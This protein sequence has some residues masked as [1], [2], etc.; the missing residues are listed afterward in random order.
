VAHQTTSG[1]STATDR[2]NMRESNMRTI[3]TALCLLEEPAVHAGLG[4]FLGEEGAPNLSGFQEGER[5]PLVE[6]NALRAIATVHR[7]MIDGRAVRFG[8]IS[9]R[10]AIAA[11]YPDSNH[12]HALA[13]GPEGKENVQNQD[14][15]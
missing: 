14:A 8:A 15:R 13:A 9:D 12:A 5:V 7:L 1:V 10:E 4:V 3:E 2:E 11:I 6:P